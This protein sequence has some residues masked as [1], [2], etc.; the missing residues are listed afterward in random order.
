MRPFVVVSNALRIA[1]NDA[2]SAP[3]RTTRRTMLPSPVV[4]AP[5][6]RPPSRTESAASV[7]ITA[8]ITTTLIRSCCANP[9]TLYQWFSLHL[10]LRQRPVVVRRAVDDGDA[11]AASGATADD[12]PRR[13]NHR[14]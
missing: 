2:P 8:A 6:N 13:R 12:S 11:P 7:R 14:P 9:V 1:L 5:A 4:G 10:A 3:K